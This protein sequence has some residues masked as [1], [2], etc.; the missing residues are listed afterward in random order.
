MLLS[1]SL[2]AL[3]LLNGMDIAWAGVSALAQALLFMC[4]NLSRNLRSLPQL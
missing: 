2:D 1:V 3:K 4:Y